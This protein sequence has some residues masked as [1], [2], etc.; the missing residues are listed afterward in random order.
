MFKAHVQELCKSLEAIAPS[1]KRAND[2]GAVQDLKA[3]AQFARQ[4][5]KETPKDRKFIQALFGFIN[6]GSTPEAAKYGAMIIL[7]VA[8]KKAMY[9]KDIF[10]QCTE[11][12]EYGIVNFSNRLA[13]LS[14]LMLLGS[15]HLEDEDNDTAIGIAINDV[16]MN[17]KAT[18]APVE[19]GEDPAWT[20]VPDAHCAAKQWAMKILANRLRAHPDDDDLDTAA[21]PVFQFLNSLIQEKGQTAPGAASL[22]AHQSRMRLSAAQMMI[23]L[24]C[25]KHLSPRLTPSAFNQL[26]L[27]AMD[28]RAQVRAGFVAKLMKYLGLTK[29]SNKFFTPLFLLGHEPDRAIKS[30][31]TTWLKGRAVAMASGKTK[32]KAMEATFARLLS[33]LAHHPDWPTPPS[34]EEET[35]ESLREFMVNIIFYLQTVGMYD[36]LGLV[37]HVAQRVKGHQ[38]GIT[39]EKNA[40]ELDIVNERLYMLSD[41]AQGVIRR[42]LDVQGWT[43]QAWPGKVK[44]PA[45]IFRLMGDAEKG[46]EVATKNFL[47]RSLEEDLDEE[48]RGL[49]KTKKVSGRASA[50]PS[51]R[52]AR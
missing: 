20:D 32:D 33:L 19:G 4:F 50:G 40:T 3:C 30:G 45:G 14:Q 7:L 47:P 22:A 25:E 42:Y 9:A 39:P 26:A 44:L 23:K 28:A 13:A 17:K 35:I 12:F 15:E 5:P 37:Y 16:L 10:R 46:R 24:C 48:V 1:A 51:P 31:V 29:L 43:L 6:H 36:N 27:V 8:D 18:P 38:D 52:S 49:L 34:S 41:L 2:A 11:G 21:K